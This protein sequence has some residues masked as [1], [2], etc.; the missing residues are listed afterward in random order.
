MPKSALE[1]EPLLD[2]LL[3]R[4]QRKRS[5]AITPRAHELGIVEPAM[6]LAGIGP[7]DR[8]EIDDLT[9]QH[10]M[11]P[12]LDRRTAKSPRHAAPH[13]HPERS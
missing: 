6:D 10:E 9:L 7:L 4:S 13:R 1:I 8:A 5:R 2:P 3:H 12:T 11:A